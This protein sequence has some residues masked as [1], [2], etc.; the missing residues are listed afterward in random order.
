MKLSDYQ[1]KLQ[2]LQNEISYLDQQR[3]ARVEEFIKCQGAIE[4]LT[5]YTCPEEGET[6]NG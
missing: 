5:N 4:A 3:Q 6:N 2:K 1:D